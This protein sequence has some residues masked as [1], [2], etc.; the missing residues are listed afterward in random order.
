MAW[1][2]LFDVPTGDPREEIEIS[3]ARGFIAALAVTFSAE[4]LVVTATA[5]ANGSQDFSYALYAR[6]NGEFQ[7]RE[8]DLY[9]FRHFMDAQIGQATFSADGRILAVAG[10]IPIVMLNDVATGKLLLKKRAPATP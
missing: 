8:L 7:R 9:G 1:V 6:T 10:C 4:S 3:P 2:L 5:R